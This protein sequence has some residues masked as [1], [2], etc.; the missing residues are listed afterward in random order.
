MIPLL[1]GVYKS[2][3][4]RREHVRHVERAEGIICLIISSGIRW[5]G[6]YLYCACAVYVMC[7]Q[8]AMHKI[9]IRA[10][11]SFWKAPMACYCSTR[12]D[13]LQ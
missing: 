1:L 3:P 6:Q 9:R 11:D 13:Q 10:K 7:V 8:K 12:N 2:W 4:A 5:N